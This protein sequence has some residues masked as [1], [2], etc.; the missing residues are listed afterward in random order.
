[1]IGVI[2]KISALQRR[3]SF[4]RRANVSVCPSSRVLYEKFSLGTNTG[5]SLT[6]GSRSLIEAAITFEKD[7]ACIE[8]GD[9]TFM[10][11]C[12]VSLA[13]SVRI[14][15]NVQVAWGTI[16]FDHDSH[17]LSA[18]L[19]RDDLANTFHGKKNWEHVRISPLVIEDDVWI[20]ANCIVLAG[21]HIGQGSVVAAGAVVTEDIPPNVLAGGNPCRVIRQI[22]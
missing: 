14:G 17:A 12:T 10:G 7:N 8:I 2:R 18:N 6:I 22:T 1:M 11:G 15:D 9:N 13:K 19:R 21:T 4:V 20:G 16:F 5:C 3:I